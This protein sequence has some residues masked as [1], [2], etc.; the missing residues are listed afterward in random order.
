MAT[1]LQS[2]I[3]FGMGLLAVPVLV[4]AG[5]PLPSAVATVIGG[6]VAQVGL[7]LWRL[8]GSIDGRVA[9]R[10]GVAAWLAIPLG[11]AVMVLLTQ[12]EPDDIRRGV[13]IAVVTVV[14]ARLAL[15]PTPRAHVARAWGWLA[16]ATS[17]FLAGLVGMGGAPLVLFAMANDWDNDRFRAFL[18]L[19]FLAAYPLMLAALSWRF[20]AQVPAHFAIGLL[21]TP[22]AWAGTW[23][24]IVATK[25]WKPGH[26]RLAATI[27]LYAIGLSG[28]V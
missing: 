4:W 23:I 2:M 13:G 26:L 1:A 14:T 20:G 11:V 19:Q 28:I 3:G 27:M 17:G 12:T 8:R 7:G 15:R 18:W 16:G 21:C 9:V 24:G 10:V 5:I 25:R 6:G 22:V